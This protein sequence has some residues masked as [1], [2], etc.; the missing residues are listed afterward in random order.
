MAQEWSPKLTREQMEQRRLKAAELFTAGY[1]QNQAALALGVNRCSTCRWFNH[2]KKEGG[3]ALKIQKGV[4]SRK[5]LNKEQIKELE[6]ILISGASEYGYETDLWTLKRISDVIMKQ[7][8]IYY[9]PGSLS[10]TL[11]MLGY[12]C[13]K[14]TRIAVNRDDRERQM[15]LKDVWEKDK[16]K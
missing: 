7:F 15:W 1:N 10:R 16:K 11:R 6:N 2:W 14:P 4:V 8:G 9:H 3:N 5:K 12:T 13:Q